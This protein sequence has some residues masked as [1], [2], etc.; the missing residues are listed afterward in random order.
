MSAEA[1]SDPNVQQAVPFF[2]I[3]DMERSLKFY[4]DGL[5]FEVKTTWTP[6]GTI[7]WCWLE[8]G[9]AAV[10]LQEYRK[11]LPLEHAPKGKL[12]EGISICFMCKDAI[13]I[14]KHAKERGLAGKTPFVGNR[15]W[16]TELTDPDGYRLAFESPTD[17]PEETVYSEQIGGSAGL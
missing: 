11:D 5:G 1:K 12:G 7:E 16:V 4:R 3:T 10:M 14:Y 8:L 15:L 9:K 6:R 2:M 13:A 17:L